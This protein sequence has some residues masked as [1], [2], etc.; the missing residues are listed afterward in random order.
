MLRPKKLKALFSVLNL[1][2][3]S[4]D[5]LYV[6]VQSITDSKPSNNLGVTTLNVWRKILVR[7]QF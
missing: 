1:S 4:L 7:N 2:N 5:F 6:V 3:E